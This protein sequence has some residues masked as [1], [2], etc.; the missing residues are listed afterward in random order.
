VS[1]NSPNFNPVE[2]FQDAVRR[3]FNQ[4]VRQHFRD[5]TA[6]DDSS[7][8]RGQLKRACLHSDSDSVLL[9]TGKLL[10]FLILKIEQLT[11]LLFGLN[12][13]ED[14]LKDQYLINAN[15]YVLVKLFFSQSA[16][17]V[18]K[19][20]IAVTAISSFRL[21]GLLR[22]VD[23]DS[24]QPGQVCTESDLISVATRIKSE[25]QG[26]RFTKGDELYIYTN[27][28]D[29]FFGSQCYARNKAEAQSLFTKLCKVAGKDFHSLILKQGTTPNRRSTNRPTGSVKA[30]NN[31]SKNKPRWRPTVIVHFRYAIADVGLNQQIV[32]FDE[33]GMLDS[34][35]VK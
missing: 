23:T 8:D 5:V 25:F 2:Q 30:Y 4:R 19:G 15:N 3:I 28:F 11:N 34:P 24:V 35:L 9:T 22:Y 27:P 29:G 12:F 16:G 18:Q 6:D 32:L 10:L 14:I 7:S 33:T 17:S 31:K 1:Y 20:K 26:F 13:E 21:V